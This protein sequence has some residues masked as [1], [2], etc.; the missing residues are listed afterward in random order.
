MASENLDFSCSKCESEE[1]LTKKFTIKSLPD[2]I[3][4]HIKRFRWEPPRRTKI[5]TP[6]DV[7][8]VIDLKDYCAN[9]S[10]STCYELYSMVNHHGKK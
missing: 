5:S 8:F 10:G 2:I 3:C 7:P 4:F 1:C 6:I 9:N